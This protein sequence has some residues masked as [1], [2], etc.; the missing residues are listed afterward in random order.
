[1][2]GS[3]KWREKSSDEISSRIYPTTTFP[4]NFVPEWTWLFRQSSSG[5][6]AFIFAILLVVLKHCS[7]L[8]LTKRSKKDFL[9]CWPKQQQQQQLQIL[10]T[11]LVFSDFLPQDV[12]MGL[13]KI[14][15]KKWTMDGIWQNNIC[16]VNLS[17]NK[18]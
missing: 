11:S 13:L 14:N 7:H 10:P 4:V 18:I 8:F 2:D 17:L 16:S 5:C 3:L 1:M 6:F 15:G 9:I 12:S